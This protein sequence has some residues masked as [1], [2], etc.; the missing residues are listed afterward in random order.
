MTPEQKNTLQLKR[1]N[2][3]HVGNGHGGGG[4]SNG[5]GGG[6]GRTIKS[7]THYTAALG[8]KFDKFSIPNDEDENESS[9]V[10]EGTSNH[11]N[12]ALTRQSKKKK[13]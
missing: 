11:S 13:R 7:L 10:E 1:L 8:T 3:C 6:K 2:R 5:K 4:N 9:E 12:A